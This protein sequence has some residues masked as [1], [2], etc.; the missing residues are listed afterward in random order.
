[1]G[2]DGVNTGQA[3]AGDQL[4][5]NAGGDVT[6]A[7]WFR[8]AASGVEM[9]CSQAESRRWGES[10]RKRANTLS[11]RTHTGSPAADDRRRP[12]GISGCGPERGPRIAGTVPAGSNHGST[13]RQ[14]EARTPWT[15]L[16]SV[17]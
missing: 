14:H 4:T 6:P 13:R 17:R 1:M 16:I 3:R 11:V 9:A 7:S 2:S 8:A 10:L 12:Q 15:H 5:R